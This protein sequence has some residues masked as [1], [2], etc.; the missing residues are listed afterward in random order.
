[1]SLLSPAQ[2]QATLTVVFTSP[3][4]TELLWEAA[5]S[6]DCFAD[7]THQPQWGHE[8]CGGWGV[9]YAAPVTV[10]VLFRS[11]ARWTS[12]WRASCRSARRS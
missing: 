3:G 10:K 11:Q 4:A 7:D 2:I 1:V 8:P 12:A 5:T 6:C 9:V